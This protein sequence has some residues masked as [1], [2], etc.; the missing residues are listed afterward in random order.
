MSG[1]GPPPGPAPPQ[2]PRRPA[3]YLPPG[4]L[5]GAPGVGTPADG[6]AYRFRYAVGASH[7]PGI[8]AL[9]PL[10]AGDVLDGSAKV[11]RRNPAAILGLAAVVNAVAVIPALVLVLGVLAGTWFQRSGVSR[12]VDTG[13]AVA[14]LLAGGGLLAT[15]A[16]SGL[17]APVVGEAVV[18]RRIDLGRAWRAARP[19]LPAILVTSLATC[20]VV[21]GPWVVVVGGVALIAAGPVPLLLLVG[22]GLVAAAFAVNVAG[23]PRVALAGP[24]VAL[25]RLGIRAGLRR[26]VDLSRGRYWSILGVSTLSLALAGL[27]FLFL[28]LIGLV[29]GNLTVDLLDLPRAQSAG[30]GQFVTALSTLFAATVVTPFLAAS[31]V[32]QY[33]DARMRKEGLD[34]VLLRGVMTRTGAGS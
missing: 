26:A 29:V 24:V 13:S 19:A 10:S 4:G 5:A 11:V 20:A 14:L 8:I 21:V 23:L 27:M 34:L 7:K 31:V 25:E 12:V 1:F 15:C 2:V 30:A 6:G 9:K 16:L 33:V 18:G 17:L 3:S 22:F 28:Q 32:L